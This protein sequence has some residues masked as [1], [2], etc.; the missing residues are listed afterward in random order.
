MYGRP[1]VTRILALAMLLAAAC[2]AAEQPEWLGSN[3]CAS[4]HAK[5]AASFRRTPMANTCGPVAAIADLP[6][7]FTFFNA[8]SNYKFTV[9]SDPLTIS[10]QQSTPDGASGSIRPVWFI[11]S[12]HVGRSFVYTRDGYLFMSP[13]SWYALKRSC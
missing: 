11:G 7:E 10:F 5:I 3:V 13:L 2:T 4:C 1:D 12:G 8:A 6:K 9:Q